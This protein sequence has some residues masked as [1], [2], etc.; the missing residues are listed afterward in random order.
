[1][2]IHS[3]PRPIKQ[4][5]QPS[6]EGHGAKPRHVAVIMD[7]NGRWAEGRG[8]SRQSGHRAGAEN[9]R[10]VIKAFAEREVPFL[11]LFAFSTE[12][13][14]RPRR[15]VNALL[16]LAGRFIDRE[17]NALHENGVRL[18]HLGSLDGLSPDLRRR[19]MEAV[20]MTR[21]N[22][23]L[24]LCIAFSYGGRAEIVDTVK[25]MI[26]EGIEPDRIDESLFDCYLNTHGLPDPDLVIRTAGE[27]RLSNFLI[28]QAAYAEFYSTNAF[29]P[30]FDEA[31]V[32]RALLA[33]AARERRFG[34]LNG[35]GSKNGNSSNNGNGAHANGLHAQA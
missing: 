29:W 1:M 30:D 35:N 7:G 9:I 32:D 15:E 34:G 18:L 23:G 6:P 14:S 21:D 31:E 11:T 25:R 12:N 33:Y 17:L 8:L 19:V 22:T 13:W 24:T 27:L 10:R 28:W 16:R 4:Q 3:R 20:E 2:V 26:A 5:S